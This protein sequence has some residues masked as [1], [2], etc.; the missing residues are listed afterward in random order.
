MNT[1]ALESCKFSSTTIEVQITQA[2]YGFHLVIALL[3]PGF[4]FLKE[5][6]SFTSHSFL[7]EENFPRGNAEC[8]GFR[9]LKTSGLTL[10]NS[11]TPQP[12]LKVLGKG[13]L[14]PLPPII[15][16]RKIRESNSIQQL[17]GKSKL[18]LFPQNGRHPEM[19][20]VAEGT[21]ARGEGR[22]S[23][24]IWDV[25]VGLVT[26]CLQLHILICIWVNIYPLRVAKCT[27]P[28]HAVTRLHL[29]QEKGRNA[30]CWSRVQ[31]TVHSPLYK[32]CG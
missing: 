10:V 11:R 31:G 24:A 32:T 5:S 17:T 4:L 29:G 20:P 25:R 19:F 21:R 18:L 23:G 30:E 26:L 8:L 16:T 6:H 27:A 1:K 12:P 22:D 2:R 9:T 14:C 15:L 3:L 7:Q 13:L 28:Q